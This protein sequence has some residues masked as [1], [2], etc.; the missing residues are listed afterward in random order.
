MEQNTSGQ[1]TSLP[2]ALVQRE[3]NRLERNINIQSPAFARANEL[4]DAT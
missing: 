3:L 4:L 2:V 1:A